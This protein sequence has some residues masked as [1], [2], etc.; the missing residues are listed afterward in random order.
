MEP[1]PMIASANLIGFLKL[2]EGFR[3]DA[4]FCVS[5][6]LHPDG[7]PMCDV[8]HGNQ[9]WEDGAPVV[10]GDSISHAK[11]ES[12]MRHWV[13]SEF[14]PAIKAYMGDISFGMNMW[15]AV[16][17]MWYNLRDPER[18]PIMMAIRDGKYG[19]HVEMTP[20]LAERWMKYHD[21]K[22][23]NIRHGLWRRRGGE[24]LLAL[25]LPKPYEHGHSLDFKEPIWPL[26][27][28]L[29][30]EQGWVVED[31]PVTALDPDEMPE[32]DTIEPGED[33]PSY[34]SKLDE[35]EQT[36]WQN[37]Q[38]RATITGEVQPPVRKAG[39]VRP[40]VRA[41]EIEDVP[42][43]EDEK[44]KV[45]PI[46]ASQRGR[47]YAKTQTGK[48]LGVVAVGGTAATAVGA[49]E[50]VVKFVDKYPQNTIAFV[51]VGLLIFSVIYYYYGLWQR[52]K[53]ED[54]ATDLLS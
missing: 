7:T 53:G 23:P 3:P 16:V 15:D 30:A 21:P 14:E 20:E 47:G 41:V 17:S 40:V 45:K 50:P 27:E 38:Q 31:E 36:E 26:V 33:L 8:G 18:Q 1:A 22:D 37:R 12:L 11:A 19:D 6:K 42:Y 52:Q 4:G 54:E 44:P 24:V 49:M 13:A 43:L 34:W 51:C 2:S 48:E 5:G 9:F 28:K 35:A 10:I 32:T 29:R 39:K 25:G 46:E